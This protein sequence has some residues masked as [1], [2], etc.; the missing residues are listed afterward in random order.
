LQAVA[1]EVTSREALASSE[2]RMSLPSNDVIE[3]IYKHPIRELRDALQGYLRD[4]KSALW[5]LIDHLDKGWSSAGLE[6]EDIQIVRGLL[7]A[8]NKLQRVFSRQGNACCILTFLRGDVYEL[9]IDTTSESGKISK[10]AVDCSDREALNQILAS[11]LR[12][13]G[14]S[15]ELGIDQMWARVCCPEVGGIGS[16][17]YILDRCLMRPRAMLG[18]VASCRSRAVNRGHERIEIEDVRDGV[19]DYSQDLLRD[20]MKELRNLAPLLEDGLYALIDAPP[21]F[22]QAELYGF[23]SGWQIKRHEWES[24]TEYLLWY[25][26]LGVEFRDDTVKYIY[27]LNYDAHL[28][29]AMTRRQ[30]TDCR[31]W[32]NSVFRP[33]LSVS[34]PVPQ[35]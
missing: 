32:I 34:E 2:A 13:A 27:D 3:I 28:F 20:V 14:L 33:A 1:K 16:L 26:V 7:D 24:L 35:V 30:G 4:R 10:V 17:D 6:I 21:S 22:S 11:R 5:V 9:L 15:P 31:Y 25:A 23:Y 8:G 12:F 19:K 29:K 18:N